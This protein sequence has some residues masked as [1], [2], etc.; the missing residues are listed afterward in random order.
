VTRP[1]HKSA[2]IDYHRRSIYTGRLVYTDYFRRGS[3]ILGVS[4]RSLSTS[5]KSRELN[6]RWSMYT[7]ASLKNRRCRNFGHIFRSRLLPADNLNL[8]RW[9]KRKLRN[10]ENAPVSAQTDARSHN[11][12]TYDVWYQRIAHFHK[13]SLLRQVQM[14]P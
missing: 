11:A 2:G 7:D 14:L 10:Y 5:D 1:V 6:Q 3:F 4:R 9:D 8:V 13:P 12:Y